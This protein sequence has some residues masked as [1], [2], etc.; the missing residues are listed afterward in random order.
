M[1]PVIRQ[2][3]I[4]LQETATAYS[5]NM[6]N[7]L[8]GNPRFLNLYEHNVAQ[9]PVTLRFYN[10]DNGR[11]I[12]NNHDDLRTYI[13]VFAGHHYWKLQTSFNALFQHLPTNSTIDI[14]DYGCGQAL[15]TTVFYDYIIR[16]NRNLR[17][18]KIILVEPSDFALKR[19]ILHLNYFIDHKD[20]DT[21]VKKVNL[22]LDNLA[23]TDLTSNNTNTK[24]HLLSNILDIDSF[25][26]NTLATKIRNSQRGTN[27]FVCVSPTNYNAETR[28]VHF[29]NQYVNQNINCI[30][31]EI[32][33]RVFNFSNRT[34]QNQY[35]IQMAQRIFKCNFDANIAR[36]TTVDD[37]DD[38]PF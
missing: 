29:Q 23:T 27:Y 37:F 34:L 16:N 12:I 35:P 19:G 20:Q 6:A 5:A 22:S 28:I 3:R 1:N 33:G 30:N 8:T 7:L 21:E 31:G 25:N 11:T 24:I 2:R 14:I 15:A 18:D 13:A 4:S 9:L 32:Q 10:L 26:L 17:V 38:L 36:P